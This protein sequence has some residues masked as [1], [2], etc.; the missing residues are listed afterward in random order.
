MVTHP[1]AVAGV[2]YPGVESFLEDF[3][4]SLRAQTYTAFDLLIFN[5]GVDQGVKALFPPQ[6]VW[7]E[8]ET[9]MSVAEI[10]DYLIGCARK[11]YLQLI[12][13]DSDDYFSPNRVA[14]SVR[15][16]STYD[17]V[18]NEV[19]LVDKGGGIQKPEY[20]SSIGVAEELTHPAQ[21]EHSNIIG[22]SNSAVNLARLPEVAI[23]ADL[24]AVDWWIYT[25][26]LINGLRGRFLRDAITFY[27]Q[28]DANTIGMKEGLTEEKLRLGLK[29]KKLHY[30]NL[31]CYCTS[32]GRVSL[33]ERFHKKLDEIA[34][35]EMLVADQSVCR[36]YLD[37]VNA[38]YIRIN[39]GWW[40]EIISLDRLECHDV[41]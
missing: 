7:L 32:S 15:W 27:R 18:Y 30:G 38:D 31:V 35:L 20:F 5:D 14:E 8:S 33:A 21:V 19:S 40:S 12:F 13:A 11:K 6:T 4:D 41:K 3:L 17:F 1:L 26:S 29:V 34:R 22:L 37:R 36:Q 28:Y 10:R 2:I 9:Q 16:L 25:V 39:D 24:I 23:P